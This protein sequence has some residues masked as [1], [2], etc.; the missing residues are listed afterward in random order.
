MKFEAKKTFPDEP[1]PTDVI[2]KRLQDHERW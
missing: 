1:E 2:L